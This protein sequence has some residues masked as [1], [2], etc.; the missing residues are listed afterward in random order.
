MLFRSEA[1]W[2]ADNQIEDSDFASSIEYLA[3]QNI[4]ELS[5][6]GPDSSPAIPAWV[7]AIAAWW[8]EGKIPDQEFVNAVQFLV[9]NGIIKV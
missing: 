4:M 9:D 5:A 3:S 2:W 7:K 8:A 6:P 1:A